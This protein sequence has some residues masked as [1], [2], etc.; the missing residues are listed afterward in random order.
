MI[1]VQS[2]SGSSGYKVN[3]IVHSGQGDGSTYQF[4]GAA[5]GVLTVKTVFEEKEES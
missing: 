4:T 2:I 5:N 3:G 1:W